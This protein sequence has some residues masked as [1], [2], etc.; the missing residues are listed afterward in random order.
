MIGRVWSV[1]LRSCAR[2]IDANHKDP[3]SAGLVH[4]DSNGVA[5]IHF[6]PDQTAAQVKAFA[7]SLER[8]GG[9]PKPEG[10]ILLVGN[11]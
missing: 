9:A 8:E 4:V 5:R 1:N 3:I 11:A 7:I 2:P 10:P 6:K